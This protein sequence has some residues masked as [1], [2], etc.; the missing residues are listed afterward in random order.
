MTNEQWLVYLWSIYPNG[1]FTLLWIVSLLIIEVVLFV[2]WL[3]GGTDSINALSR[4]GKKKVII[5]SVL[6]VLIFL[7]SLV[8]NRDAFVYILATP[9]VV[10]S[11]KS[12][13]E[14]LSDANSKLYKL[15][16]LVDNSLDKALA[17][18]EEN[19]NSK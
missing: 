9:Y 4:M 11:G 16:K 15:N 12:V 13:I 17:F 7:S 6:L 5:P 18:V 2:F 1:G 19:N 10:D 3:D 8:P 14:Q